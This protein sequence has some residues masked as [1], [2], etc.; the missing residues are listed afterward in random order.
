MGL[1]QGQFDQMEEND[2]ED[3]LEGELWVKDKFKVWKEEKDA[4]MRVKMAQSGRY[5]YYILLIIIVNS[6]FFLFRYKQYRRYMKNH[7]NDRM[8]FED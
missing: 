3:F 6:A 2:I 8:T 1:S 5:P 7:G 4:E